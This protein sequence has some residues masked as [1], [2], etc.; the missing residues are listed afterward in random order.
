[1]PSKQRPVEIHW[2]DIHATDGGWH[3]RKLADERKPAECLTVGYI[4]RESD[5]YIVLTDSLMQDGYGCLVAIPRG[6]IVKPKR[7]CKT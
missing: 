5:D 3:D 6:C 4:V 7:L 2:C 1:M